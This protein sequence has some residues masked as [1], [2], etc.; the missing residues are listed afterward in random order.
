LLACLFVEKDLAFASLL[1]QVHDPVYHANAHVILH[2]EPCYR[3]Q[4]THDRKVTVQLMDPDKMDV[5]PGTEKLEAG[6]GL[7]G[8][9]SSWAERGQYRAGWVG[10]CK[11]AVS[12]DRSLGGQGGVAGVAGAGV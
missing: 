11:S 3:V 6:R 2:E 8:L 7:P 9:K 4:H 10:G 5:P 1:V 12:V